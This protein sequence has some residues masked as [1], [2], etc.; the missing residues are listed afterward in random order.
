[1]EKLG[2]AAR[3]IDDSTA[4]RKAPALEDEPAEAATVILKELTASDRDEGVGT[5]HPVH[6]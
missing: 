4:A 1:M 6:A 5:D 2:A 3:V